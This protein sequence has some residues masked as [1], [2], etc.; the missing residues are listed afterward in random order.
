MGTL[1]TSSNLSDDQLAHHHH[2]PATCAVA[3]AYTYGNGGYE[4][5][6]TP[7]A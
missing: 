1:V 2:P 5:K 3:G 6:A 4:D 7:L